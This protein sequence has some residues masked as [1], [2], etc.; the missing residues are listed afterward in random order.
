MSFRRIINALYKRLEY[1]FLLSQFAFPFGFNKKNRQK[2][3]ELK[4]SKSGRCF[5]IATGPSLK[6]V[7]FEILKDE[8]TITMNRGYL[9]KDQVDFKP[10]MLVCID[11]KTQINQFTNFYDNIEDV[12]TFYNWRARRKMRHLE[13]RFFVFSWFSPRFLTNSIFGG[14]KSVTYTCIQLAYHLG[15]QEV[16]LVGKDHYYT[17]KKKP[18]ESV[19][20]DE[21]TNNHFLKSYYMKNQIYDS[22]DLKKEEHAY[23]I[24]KNKFDSESRT[25][26]DATENGKL[27]VFEK[28]DFK[29]IF[30]IGSV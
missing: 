5:I 19:I 8:F 16:Y 17:T 23:S 2:F 13:N 27:E 20:V 22:P 15:F 1:P 4:N 26:M 9:L 28:I 11:M 21:N 24:A 3:A 29:D 6:N 18:S 30:Q 12:P 14:G 10:S 7:D 25:I